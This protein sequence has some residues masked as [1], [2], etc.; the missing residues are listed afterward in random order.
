MEYRKYTKQSPKVSAIGYGA[1]QLG[2]GSSWSKMTDVEAISLVHHA[3]DEGVNF[4]DTS[5][6][7]GLGTSETLL[8]KAFFNKDRRKLVINSK[9]GHTVEG[10]TDFSPEAIRKSVEGSLKRLGTDYLDSILLHNPSE[11]MMDPSK[12]PHYDILE[13]L[14]KE[15]KILAYG[16]SLDSHNDMDLFMKQTQGEIIETFFNILHQDTRKSF[17]L[18]KEKDVILIAK[19]PLDSGWLSGKYHQKST[20]KGIR[21]RW[22]ENEIIQRAA[23]VDLI[24]ALPE[25]GQSLAQL[26]LSYCLSYDLISTVIPGCVNVSQLL[27]NIKSLDY[28]MKHSVKEQIEVLYNNKIQT[29][30]LPW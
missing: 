5:P 14:K 20:F 8:G 25:N 29:M 28:P 11:T 27:D 21:S 2:N 1:W 7:Y 9:F 24:R 17:D 12:V 19:I 13:A 23:A 30:Q 18:A 3:L 10:H 6:N 16:A 26:A 22:S 15:G 4:F